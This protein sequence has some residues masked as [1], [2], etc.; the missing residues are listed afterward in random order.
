MNEKIDRQGIQADRL[1]AATLGVLLAVTMA[2]AALP[3]PGSRR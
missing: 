1:M 3:E 2:V